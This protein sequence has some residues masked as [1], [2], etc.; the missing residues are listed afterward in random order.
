MVK[1]K[2]HTARNQTFKAHRNGIKRPKVHR[3]RSTK[4]T[5]PKFLRN[6]RYVQKGNKVA[7]KKIRKALAAKKAGAKK[8]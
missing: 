3:Y 6:Q 2:I 1:Q 5:D 4:G 7:L 8:A